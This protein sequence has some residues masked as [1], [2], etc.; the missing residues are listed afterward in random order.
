M[1]VSRALARRLFAPDGTV[2]GHQTR[3]QHRKYR[4]LLDR[5]KRERSSDQSLSIFRAS[6]LPS[7]ICVGHEDRFR[8]DNTHRPVDLWKPPVSS[9]VFRTVTGSIPVS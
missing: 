7:E 3:M 1:A 5:P 6:G 8:A 9:A 4:K 2:R